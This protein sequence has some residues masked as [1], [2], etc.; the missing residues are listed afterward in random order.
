MVIFHCYVS[1]PEGISSFWMNM[2]SCTVTFCATLLR[3]VFFAA[4]S[5][6]A[7]F[8]AGPM[9]T[10][11]H[12]LRG[13][14]QCVDGFLMGRTKTVYV[15]LVSLG[16]YINHINHYHH[17]QSVRCFP[18]PVHLILSSVVKHTINY[19]FQPF[20]RNDYKNSFGT[21]IVRECVS[22]WILMPGTNAPRCTVTLSAWLHSNVS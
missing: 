20:F 1:S 22:C 9:V 16:H 7:N 10:G 19:N 2:H 15:A 8:P 14:N 12:R 13:Q 21:R 6:W 17:Y 11:S 4:H 5:L 3:G 18:L